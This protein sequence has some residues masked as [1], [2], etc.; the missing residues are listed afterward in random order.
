MDAP[1]ALEPD[2][3]GRGSSGE[4]TTLARAASER[5]TKALP[6][7]VAVVVTHNPGDWF[8]TALGSLVSQEYPNLSI[9]VVDAAS[10]EDPT[11]R[12]ARITPR[13]YVRRLGTNP[14]FGAAANT[15]LGMV[16]G[17]PFFLVCHDD[18]A[19]APGAVRLLVEEA[20]R[21]N[22]GVVGPK[23]A[24]W[25]EPEALLSVGMGADRFGAPFP[26]CERGELD[27]E[28]HDGVRDVFF[29]PSAALLIRSDLMRALGG[30]D[31]AIRFHGEDLDLCWRAHVA[32][33]RVLVAPSARARHVE[34]LAQRRPDDR[35]RLQARNRLRMVLTNYSWFY[36]VGEVVQQLV[37]TLAETLLALLTGRPRHAFDLL[38]AWV[39]NP[40][41]A[42]S[43]L[44]KRRRVAAIRGVT[45]LEVRH[46]HV[47]G[48]ARL[49]RFLRGQI[50][51]SNI[52]TTVGDS[53]RQWAV[54]RGATLQALDLAVVGGVAL[55][56]LFGSR[57]LLRGSLPAVGEF[58]LW[59]DRARDLF[60]MAWSGWLS[61]GMGSVGVAPTGLG[62]IGLVGLAAFG[63]TG[64]ARLVLILGTIP[65]GLAGVWR[66]GSFSA[67]SRAKAAMTLA[68]AA[69]P[70]PYA[71]LADGRWRALALYGL[72]PWIVLVGATAVGL[73]PFSS[74]QRRP[75]AHAVAV[76]ALLCALLVTL[77][78]AAVIVVALSAAALAAGSVLTGEGRK[79]VAL[80][81]LLGAGA[82]GSLV[83]HGPW[84]LSAWSSEA[85]A[86]RTLG[87]ADGAATWSLSALA[88][89]AIGDHP[90][91]W[92]GWGLLVAGLA[93]LGYGRGWRLGWAV[94]GWCLF[95]FPL[96][97]VALVQL[98][99]LDVGLPAP[100]VLLA[101]AALGVTLAV[102]A[103]MAAIDLD[104]P[105]YRFGWRQPASV[106]A[107]AGLLVSL[108]GPV[109]LSVDGA[110]N[111]P[112]GGHDRVLGFVGPE[113][114]EVGPFR[115]LWL[116][117]PELL[118]LAGWPLGDGVSGFA[119]S[120]GYPSVEGLWAGP[121]SAALERVPAALTSAREG[122]NNRLGQELGILGIRYVVVVDRL[123]PAPFDGP[124]RSAAPWIDA[125]LSSQLDL[126]EV[127]LNAA[128]RLYRNTAWLPHTTVL[129][130][131][132]DQPNE[133]A[134][135]DSGEG[136]RAALAASGHQLYTGTVPDGAVLHLAEVFDTGWQLQVDGQQVPA[137]V[138]F[139]AT[140]RFEV[141]QGGPARLFHDR[142]R[143]LLVPWIVQMV[144]WAGLIALVLRN[145]RLVSAGAA[146]Q[147]SV[148][149]EE[150]TVRSTGHR[151]GSRRRE[152]DPSHRAWP[153]D[154]DPFDD[155]AP[156]PRAGRHLVDR[157]PAPD[158]DTHDEDFSG[159]LGDER[160]PDADLPDQDLT[161]V[162]PADVDSP[163]V[164]P[165]DHDPD[166]PERASQ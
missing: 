142:R 85:P 163:D 107:A 57:S 25:D 160:L 145:R 59:P 114:A 34:A 30:F 13:A 99:W 95:T 27:Q 22:A 127:E 140:T 135:P 5:A 3:G 37:L 141:D 87:D 74:P 2:P 79:G 8:E 9:L 153:G 54:R 12:I 50:S 161:D 117:S 39:W 23:L 43:I 52:D 165:A 65:L 19:L 105:A 6:A 162:E 149:F 106:L 32:G 36:A 76:V 86:L 63:A 26:L 115:V 84:L 159:D 108:L 49:T 101:P 73:A 21:S 44:A 11:P 17:S 7:V 62:L 124:T 29:V 77:Y 151:F 136:A 123:A 164:E 166:Q 128:F 38:S 133:L 138:G 113:T 119:T 75:R 118:P 16:E 58:A 143:A 112:R 104:L 80:A 4:A 154:D 81:A 98:G 46:L 69:N 91:G 122:G 152:P 126:A 90:V 148:T 18:V 53:L 111:L 15:A 14:G 157:Q 131:G 41:G 33:A 110:W 144:V 109:I 92:V 78:P 96:L 116:G 71:A 35:R 61:G 120:D 42:G 103:S 100:E 97:A 10:D 70:L 66:L 40:R 64:L 60:P 137:G 125:T 55:V 158:D 150:T 48:S 82:L 130:A 1:F 94:R 146:G 28:Q 88:R 102:G 31:E 147:P 139:G 68:Y 89:F 129:E 93:G 156:P 155:G 45:D 20:Y 47:R 72:L 56:L 83:L 67:D 24:Q 132:V 121:R 51:G 134:F